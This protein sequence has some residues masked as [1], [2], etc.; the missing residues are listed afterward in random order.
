MPI[1]TQNAKRD[2]NFDLLMP[3]TMQSGKLVKHRNGGEC[4]M[5]KFAVSLFM[6]SHT[7][8]FFLS[9]QTTFTSLL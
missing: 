8:C 6:F 5:E 4:S 3:F 7:L 9:S 1:T 2:W